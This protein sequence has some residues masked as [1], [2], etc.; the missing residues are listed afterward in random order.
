MVAI[1]LIAGNYNG[2]QRRQGLETEREPKSQHMVKSQDP[3]RED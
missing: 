1:L 3:K 2:N